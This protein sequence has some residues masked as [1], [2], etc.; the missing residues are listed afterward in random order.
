MKGDLLSAENSGNWGWQ[1]A[2]TGG[3]VGGGDED[4]AETR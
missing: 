1:G 4:K 3:M 2:E